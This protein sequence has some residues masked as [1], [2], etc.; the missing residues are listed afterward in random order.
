[1][2]GHDTQAKL[3]G[4]RLTG[5]A[6]LGVFVT[7]GARV[8]LTSCELSGNRSTGA[9]L[10]GRGTTAV[11]TRCCVT[12]NGR[13][14]L[15]VHSAALAQLVGSHV[16]ASADCAIL[17]GGVT[18]GGLAGGLVE[19]STECRVRGRLLSC[20]GGRIRQVSMGSDDTLEHSG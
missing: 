3:Q 8:E 19:H 14:G 18:A 4:C 17:C 5:N 6:T 7:K 11:W 2:Q 12:D 13:V 10:T 1:M 20:H 15:Y 9:E 16:M